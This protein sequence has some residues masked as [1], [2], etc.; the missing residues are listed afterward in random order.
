MVLNISREYPL[1]AQGYYWQ[2]TALGILP[3]EALSS[4]T[5]EKAVKNLATSAFILVTVSSTY[6]VG[7]KDQLFVMRCR[8]TSDKGELEFSTYSSTY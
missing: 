6:K 3:R 8:Q 5:L 7:D 1:K 2:N 4:P